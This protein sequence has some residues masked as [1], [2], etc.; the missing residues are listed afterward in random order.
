VPLLLAVLV[1]LPLLS[2]LGEL[3]TPSI[4]LWETLWATLL[5][6]MIGNTVLLGAGVGISTLVL[7]TGL[8][9]LVTAYQFPGRGLFER[10]LMLP[11]AVPAFVIG[12]VYV[13]LFDIAGPVQTALRGVFGATF[14]LPEIRSAA[15]AI[16]VLT[17]V[18]YPY[19]YLLARQAL[20]DQ[21][22]NL[23]EV[24][25]TLG[26]GRTRAF[27]RL[28]VPL[29]RPAL[30]AGMMLAVMEAV[31]D[32]ATV[33]FFS[34]S[35]VSEGI[36][37]VWEG[38]M[39]RGAAAELS[40]LLLFLLVTL[41][42][43]ERALRGRRR[44]Y[45]NAGRGRGLARTPL[46]G[47]GRWA[48]F[49]ACSLVLLLAFVLPVGQLVVW[50]AAHLNEQSADAWQAVFWRYTS[51]TAAVSAGAALL[52]VLLALILSHSAR[53]SRSRLTRLTVRAATL[54][55]GIPGAVIAAGIL[56]TLTPV[57]QLINEIAGRIGALP[58]GLLLTGSLVGLT[59]GYVVRFLAVGYSSVNASM[60][61]IKPHYAEAARTL[62][63]RNL[64]VLW[65]VHAPLL[66]SGL[67]T[68]A[69]L[70]FVDTIKELPATLFLR[71]FGMDTLSIWT[72]MAASESLW[73]EAALPA[74]TILGISIIPVLL[75]MR[76]QGQ[77]GE[78][79]P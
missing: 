29:A 40:S 54:G 6:R 24:A 4:S 37:R 35:T 79:R 30:V 15:G 5:P 1:I 11:M 74:L 41:F 13:G 75:L 21:A 34:V 18:L 33:R 46:Y 31:T 67:L 55:Y 64:R 16:T 9:W 32:F 48:A 8:A 39:D 58:P 52:T 20:R 38:R 44:F 60:E 70:V 68:G 51:A 56:I 59:Y 2:V 12:F 26:Y 53:L 73:K 43:L 19:V 71:P 61:K 28:L 45:Q 78:P 62:G 7:G 17:L 57:D 23:L 36:V 77:P 10:A 42:I 69:L 3:L 50:T 76:D 63:A 47:G 66:R 49:S 14:R 22:A 27:F 25:R 65:Q 72:Y